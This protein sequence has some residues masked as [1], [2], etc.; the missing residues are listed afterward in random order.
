MIKGSLVEKA[1]NAIIRPPRRTYD[2]SELPLEIEGS[3]G[4]VFVRH[5]VAFANDR[6]QKIVGSIYLKSGKDITSGGPC[7]I[8]LHGNASSQHEGKYLVPDF[9]SN[10]VAV[11]CFDFPGSGNSDGEY[12]SLGY[13]ETQDLTF[14][15]NQLKTSFRMGPFALWGRSMG[16]ATAV[17]CTHSDVC[18][19]VVDSANTSIPDVCKA[20]AINM[21]L[22]SIFCPAVLWFLKVHISGIANFDISEVSALNIA[23]QPNQPPLLMCHAENDEFV[24][25]EEGQQIFQAYTNP[26]KTFVKSQSGHNGKRGPAWINQACMFI[27]KHFGITSEKTFTQSSSR[28]MQ[29]SS[30]HF[31]SYDDLVK[32]AQEHPKEEIE[33][34]SPIMLSEIENSPLLS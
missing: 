15:I 21:K 5:P 24:P 25:Y 20:I 3:N 19:K 17:M 22:P 14:L 23:K 30:S 32:F 4:Q 9:C 13:F 31:R 10:D 28:R 34:D 16:A 29:E 26:D 27:L 8:Y 7:M 18:C 6:D 11:F 33:K 1:V 12:I 2:P